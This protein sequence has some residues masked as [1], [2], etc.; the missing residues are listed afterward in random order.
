MLIE[1]PQGP[2][3]VEIASLDLPPT[4][5]IVLPVCRDLGIAEVVDRLCPMHHCGS[6]SHGQVIEFL[7]LHILQAPDREPL[8]K[9]EEWAADHNV[10]FVFGCEP[11]AFNDDRVGRALE[12]I[13]QQ[14][15]AIE[16][17]L[18]TRAL[19]VY[20]V[21]VE[22][23]HWDLTHVT[24]T[25]VYENSALVKRGYGHGQ[26]HDKQ[27]NISLHTTGAHAIPVRHETLPGDAH[28][29]PL[30]G[31]M[32]ADLQRRL[33]KTD[34]LVVSDC[35]GISYDNIVVYERGGAHFLGPLQLT[36]AEQKF[37]A[38][39]PREA[40]VPLEY[41]SLSNPDC[42]YSCF[43]TSLTLERQKRAQP[44]HVRALVMHSTQK[45]ERDAGLRQRKLD[46]T[47]QRLDQIRG[48]LNKARYARE[49]Y[50]RAQLEKAI[51]EGLQGIVEYELSGEYKKLCLQTSVDE[52]AFQQAGC[53]DGRWL[54]VC[55]DRERSAPELFALQREHYTIEACFR[56]FG[57][58]L[59]V[60]PVFLHNEDR[61]AGLMLVFIIALMVYCLLELCSVRAKLEGDHYHKMTTR[62]LLYH[63]NTRG[64]KLLQVSTRGHPASSRVQ[65]SYELRYILNELGFPDPERYINTQ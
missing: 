33:Q 43:D 21:P 37:V 8:Y 34:L 4:F 58:D 26:V 44:L 46:K 2:L 9:L 20:R 45:Q 30:A 10:N 29:A 22:A 13:S 15:G 57:H 52:A 55:D 16:A 36:P 65:L 12:A 38:M 23:I 1:T 49:D 56:S 47:L 31:A 24:F 32:L 11:A 48:H 40:F 54:L 42:R 25:G 7:V 5:P 61:I 53:A 41:R 28:Q 50:A 35:A 63:F 59:A 19:E 39:V 62:Q 3:P 27:L 51:P 18:V 64:V 17:A 60:Q 14:V 6:L